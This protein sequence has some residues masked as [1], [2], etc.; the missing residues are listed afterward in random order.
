MRTLCTTLVI[1]ATFGMAVAT[2]AHAGALLKVNV[3]NPASSCNLSIPSTDTKVR[4]KASGFRNEGTTNQ[5]VICGF[6]LASSP[7]PGFSALDMY[8]SSFD[9]VAHTFDCTA[10]A[11]FIDG[12]TGMYQ[13]KSVT[14][15]AD[16]QSSE[17]YI[18]DS[19]PNYYVYLPSQSITCTLPPGVAIL[20]VQS[21]YTDN[22]SAP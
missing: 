11:R 9:G 18:D 4:P 14:T 3:Q 2:P 16:G 6:D 17:L 22:D 15:H 20:T 13:T 7:G 8:F 10:M 5:F 1:A 21:V 19:N 12:S